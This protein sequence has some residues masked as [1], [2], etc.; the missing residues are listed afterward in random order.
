MYE[1]IR[2]TA[3]GYSLTTMCSLL[4]CYNS[5]LMQQDS[6]KMR[7]AKHLWVTNIAP[8]FKSKLWCGLFHK[9]LFK[10]RWM[11]AE[12]LFKQYLFN[13]CHTRFVIFF[14][15]PS[16]WVNS[17]IIHE[18]SCLTVCT[19]GSQVTST[20]AI[21]STFWQWLWYGSPWKYFIIIQSAVVMRNWNIIKKSSAIIF[22]YMGVTWVN[23]A[24][25]LAYF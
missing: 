19:P 18:G 10:G 25:F 13:V 1:N 3:I 6:A 17:L 5:E 9:H 23:L 8:L 4:Y 14:P 2:Y 21:L 22:I 20:I 15:L 7:M 11:L 24:E 12:N 16:F